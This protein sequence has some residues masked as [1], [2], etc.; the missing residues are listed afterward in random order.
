[1]ANKKKKYSLFIDALRLNILNILV[2]L[3]LWTIIDSID[4][5]NPF[6]DV[7]EDFDYTD[8]YFSKFKSSQ[9]PTDTNIFIVN[10]GELNRMELAMMI[11][12]LQNFEP[13][14]IG[15]DAVFKEKRGP[16]DLFLRQALTQ[17]DNSVLGVFGKY[18]RDIKHFS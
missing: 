6:D 8:L 14:V 16:E 15:V 18:T 9:L 12:T 13:K 2:L 17:K 7:L 3:F 11:N 5:F 10:I 4:L 1:M